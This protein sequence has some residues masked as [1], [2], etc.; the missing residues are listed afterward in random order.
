[1]LDMEPIG[2]RPS[3]SDGGG[4]DSSFSLRL[5]LLPPRFDG[6]NT[7]SRDSR[8]HLVHGG[9]EGA[10]ISPWFVSLTL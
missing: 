7:H 4:V 2:R 6:A 5:V 8:L 1:M 10:S 9:S 3:I